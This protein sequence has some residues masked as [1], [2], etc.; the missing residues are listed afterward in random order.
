MRSTHLFFL[1]SC[2]LVSTAKAS[3]QGFPA[4]DAVKRMRVPE[5]F[6]VEVV[7]SEP[8]VK[9]PVCVEFDDRGRLW[10]IQY[11]QY[12][13]P[14]GLQRT[15]VDRFSRTQYDKVPEPPPRGPKGADRITILSDFDVNGL[16]QKSKDFVTG[17][18]LASGMAFGNGGVYILQV[19]YLLFYPDKNGDDIPDSD[20][21][22][23][24][25]GFGLDD[26][27]SV[28]NSLTWGP[29]GWLYGC[30]GST[31]TA[32]IRGI[33]FQQGVWRYHPPTKRFELFCEG[34]GNSWGFDFD[35]DGNIIYSTNFGGYRALHAVQGAYYWKQ[36]GKHGALHNPYAYGF[37]DHMPHDNFVGGHV[38]VSGLIYR[39]DTFPEMYRDQYIHVDTLGHGI[40]WSKF[41]QNGSSFKTKH[42]GE[43]L[44]GN[45]SWF[46]PC[47]A[48]VGPD[49][50]LYFADWYD[51]RTA[52][53]DPDAD[54]DRSNGRVYKLAYGQ[55]NTAP[56]LDLT[57]TSS[58]RLIKELS[59]KNEWFVRKAL[60][61][62]GDRREVASYPKLR[63]QIFETQDEHLA[64]VSLWALH[65]S[66]GG[67]EAFLNDCLD[68]VS[69]KIRRW[70]IRFLGDENTLSPTSGEHL[71]SMAGTEPDVMVRSQLVCTA[72]RLPAKEG[73]LIAQKIA[74][75]NLDAQDPHIP[76]LLWW[77][78]E[79]HCV[80]S[81]EETERLFGD[82]SASPLIRD[83]I[84]PRLM[85]RYAAEGRTNTLSAC[86]RMLG[87][88]SAQRG[89]LLASLEQGL[90]E[91][92]HESAVTQFERLP[93]N[94]QTQLTL[95]WK[96]DSRD[97]PVIRILSRLSYQ[98]ARERALTLAE[99]SAAAAELRVAM[100]QLIAELADP[101]A[102]KTLLRLSSLDQP[103]V[104]Q[105][106]ALDAIQQI[107]NAEISG[108]LSTYPKM[109]PR[110]RSQ[111][112][113]VL[114]SHKLWASAFLKGVDSGTYDAKEVPFDQLQTVATFEDKE[115][116]ELVRKHWG[117]IGRGTP[118][119]K[120]ADIRRFN[121]DLR[122]GNGDAKNGHELFVKN[123]AACHELFGEGE[124]VGPELTHANRGD[125]SFLL[126][127]IVDPSAVIRKE[128][129]NYNI[130]T[131]DGSVLSG[132]VSEQNAG[133][134]TLVAAKN[135]RNVVPRE[136]I[137]SMEE[138]AISL[139]PE[140]LLHPLTPQERRDLFSY[141]Q[142]AKPPTTSKGSL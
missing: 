84:L 78:V 119:E 33:E 88:I 45:D 102:L 38:T 129:L 54:W 121:N 76:L 100:L 31:V 111:A 8:T 97:A 55:P 30:Q 41:E 53:P 5:G 142:S 77:T 73:L 137:L 51:K 1:L 43:L 2:A 118:E 101:K 126:A 67:D 65:A 120:L 117:N 87:R 74:S 109:N 123:C 46:A 91:Q 115:L 15:K 56:V 19:P 52:H 42:G 95:L 133:G 58:D 71:V 61:I 122:A 66:G 124:K 130:E 131:K 63:A 72:K 90:V 68:H 110:V 98:P 138:S 64:L 83:T 105:L 22:V 17:L 34:G 36:F 70:A 103:E 134:V 24:L 80:E 37:I 16:A 4:K 29:D 127:S 44:A 39:G 12:P 6:R 136:K 59:E 125:Q 49:G 108:I 21:E 48:T 25:T 35:K 104:I 50:A 62:L 113:G 13:N 107:P 7:A 60:R 23:L 140:G 9:Q 112:R 106:A 57:R 141:L 20:P 116:N 27:H 79:K 75:R 14:A 96:P 47:D 69:P 86:A 128:F 3:A 89:Q 40:L 10:V 85:R 94:L 32:N 135:Q 114:L 99:D 93:K 11:L 92:N 26:A 139:M 81:I 18:N 28:A 82:E 132:L